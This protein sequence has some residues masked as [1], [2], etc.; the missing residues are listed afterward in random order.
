MDVV[1]ALRG[2]LDAR[3]SMQSLEDA[4]T[5]VFDLYEPQLNCEDEVVWFVRY[6]EHIARFTG[7]PWRTRGGESLRAD[8][9]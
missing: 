6:L 5:D 2:E 8:E 7:I 9:G 4:M 1:W 3:A